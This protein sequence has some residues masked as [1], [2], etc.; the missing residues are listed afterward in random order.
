MRG[1]FGAN[2]AKSYGSRSADIPVRH[3]PRLIIA[4]EQGP[5][6]SSDT[7]ADKNVRAPRQYEKGGLGEVREQI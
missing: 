5:V 3:G 2:E 6:L 1:R 4:Q 7:A